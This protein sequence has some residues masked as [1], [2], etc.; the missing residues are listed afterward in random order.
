VFGRT[1][2]RRMERAL[3]GEYVQSIDRA[4]ARLAPETL[5]LIIELA[6][7]PE[8]MRGFGHVKEANIAKAKVRWAAIE[9]QL[10]AGVAPAA[11]P[12]STSRTNTQRAI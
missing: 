5:P 6:A 1:A 11:A 4:L 3:I 9:A 2:E 8:K 10:A 7:L 12:A